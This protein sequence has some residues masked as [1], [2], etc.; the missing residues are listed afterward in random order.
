MDG[1]ALTYEPEDAY[2]LGWSSDSGQDGWTAKAQFKPADGDWLTLIRFECA[3]IG[4]R[5]PSRRRMLAAILEH[6]GRGSD[7]ALLDAADAAFLGLRIPAAD[8]AALVVSPSLF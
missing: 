3:D 5:D 1:D 4:R 7:D 6:A 2:F 8:I